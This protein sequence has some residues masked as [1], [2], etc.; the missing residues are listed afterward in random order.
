[1]YSISGKL[2]MKNVYETEKEIELNVSNMTPG[3]YFIVVNNQS[4]KLIVK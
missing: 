1:L 4:H 3:L 2:Q